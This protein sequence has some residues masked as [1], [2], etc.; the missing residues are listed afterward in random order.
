MKEQKLRVLKKSVAVTPGGNW[1]T[2]KHWFPEI[3]VNQETG[4]V[5]VTYFYTVGHQKKASIETEWIKIDT[6]GNSS[7]VRGEVDCR[8]WQNGKCSGSQQFCFAIFQGDSGHIYTHRAPATKGW[9]NAKPEEIRKRLRRLGVGV[10]EVA[11]QQ[12]DFLLKK[13]NGLALPDDDFKHESTGAGHHN[14]D[15]PVL[16]AV[17]EKGRR[18]YWVKEAVT[19]THRAVDGIQHPTVTVEP[20]KYIVGSTTDSLFHRNKRD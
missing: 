14:F 19:L 20:G 1:N 8:N 5:R 9:M 13:A 2:A 7:F 15:V 3:D 16:Y 4:T 18:Q 17:D 10:N 6:K 12:G 11:Y